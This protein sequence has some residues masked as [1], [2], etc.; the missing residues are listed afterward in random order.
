MITARYQMEEIVTTG[1]IEVGDQY[2]DFCCIGHSWEVCIIFNDP[3]NPNW[4]SIWG[5]CKN[6]D[7]LIFQADIGADDPYRGVKHVSREDFLEWLAGVAEEAKY[8]MEA[9]SEVAE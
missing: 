9:R 8:P 3:T 7:C 4:N 1:E 6:M 5:V 2:H